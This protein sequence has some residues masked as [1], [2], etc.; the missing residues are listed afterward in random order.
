MYQS[1]PAFTA[2]DATFASSRDYKH[3]ERN[4]KSFLTP[5]ER[6]RSNHEH[7]YKQDYSKL[8]AQL[9]ILSKLSKVLSTS[10]YAPQVTQGRRLKL[11]QTQMA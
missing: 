4:G 11:R 2:L 1:L 9:S 6:S 8:Y 5:R 3:I 7:F 10:V